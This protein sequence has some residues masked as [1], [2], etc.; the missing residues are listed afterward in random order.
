MM[1]RK[2][3]LA[4]LLFMD[5]RSAEAIINAAFTEYVQL[6]SDIYND[7]YDSCIHLYYDQ[8]DP[9]KYDRHGDPSGFNLYSASDIYA[10]DLR[11]NLSLEA[12]K[13]LPYKGKGDKRSRVLNTVLNGLRGAGSRKTPPGWPMDWDAHYPNEFSVLSDWSSDNTTLYSILQ[14]FAKNGSHELSDKFYEFIANRI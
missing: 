8:Y 3:I 2:N 14:D 13:L 7:I 6:I 10:N 4:S 9:I 1:D 12:S 5:E 11:V